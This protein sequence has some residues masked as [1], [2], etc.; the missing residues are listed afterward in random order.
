[1]D[2]AMPPK[3]PQRTLHCRVVDS[4]LPAFGATL[5]RVGSVNLFHAYMTFLSQNSQQTVVQKFSQTFGPDT[6]YNKYHPC[7]ITP[8]LS[9]KKLKTTKKRSTVETIVGST[10]VVLFTFWLQSDGEW[11]CYAT[12]A[13]GALPETSYVHK[14]GTPAIPYCGVAVATG[15]QF[16]GYLVEHF[17]LTSVRIC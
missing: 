3:F 16:V 13:C 11:R 1:M 17:C 12:P 7:Q 6:E 9:A 5:R 10:V 14:A 2:V 4:F 8:P 15:K